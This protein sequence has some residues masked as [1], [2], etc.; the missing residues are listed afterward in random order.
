[1]RSPTRRRQADGRRG[2]RPGTETE[3]ARRRTVVMSS[4]RAAAP[5]RRAVLSGRH[6]TSP[7]PWPRSPPASRPPSSGGR[8]D[9]VVLACRPPVANPRRTTSGRSPVRSRPVPRLRPCAV[10]PRPAVTVHSPVTHGYFDFLSQKAGKTSARTLSF[11]VDGRRAGTC[12]SVHGTPAT[13]LSRRARSP[14]WRQAVDGSRRAAVLAEA[15]P[16]QLRGHQGRWTSRPGSAPT[17]PASP[18]RPSSR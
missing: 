8:R 6:G 17:P 11:V 9:R 7:C 5:V 15:P 10:D 12:T 3:C 1:M 2:H 16:T 4:A 18:A 14:T 13:A